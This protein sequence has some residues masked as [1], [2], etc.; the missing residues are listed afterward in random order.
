MSTKS[1]AFVVL[2]G[3]VVLI[4][5]WAV[6]TGISCHNRHVDIH[7]RVEAQ[8]EIAKNQFDQMWKVVKERANVAENYADAFRK[9]YGEIMNARYQGSG[10]DALL[11]FIQESN[12]QFDSSIYRDLSASIEGQRG[13]FT[14]TQ[15]ALADLK[16]E[17]DAL[18]EKWPG[19]LFIRDKTPVEVQYVRSDRTD[20]AFQSGKDNEL[21]V[22]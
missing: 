2:L 16:R 21:L 15:Q 9:A 14:A 17:H 12:P 8:Q 13:E 1:V 10:N 20:E 6:S 3:I 4:G 18:V 19:M 5:L 7:K 22:H 11:R